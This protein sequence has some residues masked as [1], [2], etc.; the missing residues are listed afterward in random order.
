MNFLAIANRVKTESG[1]SGGPIVS[2]LT[3]FGDDARM[4]G[5]INVAWTRIQNETDWRW[6]RKSVVKDLLPNIMR[7]VATDVAGFNLANVD[8]WVRQGANYNPLTYLASAPSLLTPLSV[9]PDDAFWRDFINAAHVAAP[10]M[11]WSVDYNGDL[12]IGPKPDVAR[13]LVIDYWSTNQTLVLDADIPAMPAKFHDLLVWGALMELA[14][15]DA[16]P[17]VYT[18]AQGNYM[19]M[20]SDLRYEQGPRMGLA[21]RRIA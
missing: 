5:W 2:A 16:A 3:A 9:Y 4:F 6:M 18:R 20:H 13:K 10:P 7:Y 1:R 15:F 8:R 11:Y 17:E 14:S 12:L 19:S 21:G